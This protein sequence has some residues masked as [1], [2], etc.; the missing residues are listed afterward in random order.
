MQ[1]NR[2]SQTSTPSSSSLSPYLSRLYCWRVSHKFL[3]SFFVALLQKQQF[4][5]NLHFFHISS[6]PSTPFFVLHNNKNSSFCCKF[7]VRL[8]APCRAHHRPI[9][10]PLADRFYRQLSA[11]YP[12]MLVA[13]FPGDKQINIHTH[14]HIQ[15]YTPARGLATLE[16]F[17]SLL[18]C[19]YYDYTGFKSWLSTLGCQQVSFFLHTNCCM[20]THP[21]TTLLKHIHIHRHVHI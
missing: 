7:Q 8:T 16:G 13:P 5:F 10:R 21:H 19:M 3:A 15:T 2:F 17:R 18:L 6:A 11:T 14:T 20:L 12:E 1:F 4:F 9:D